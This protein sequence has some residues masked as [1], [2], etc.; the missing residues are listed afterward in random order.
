MKRM[1][2]SQAERKREIGD[3]EKK[4]EK[5]REGDYCTHMQQT[6]L[7]CHFNEGGPIM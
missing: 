6:V 7:K 2:R 3:R 4:R 1:V 5:E